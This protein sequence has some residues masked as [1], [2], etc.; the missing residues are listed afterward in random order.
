LESGLKKH[1]IFPHDAQPLLQCISLK[2]LHQNTVNAAFLG[3]VGSTTTV[4]SGS[5]KNK[6]M[7]KKEN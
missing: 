7:K 2:E 5:A 4:V 6:T 1:D 3:I